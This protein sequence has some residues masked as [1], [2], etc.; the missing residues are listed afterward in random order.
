MERSKSMKAHFV[1]FY[2]PGTFFAEDTTKPIDSW[3]VEKARKM[4]R[5]I[6]E[7]Y[8]ARPFGFRFTTRERGPKALDSHVTKTS[9]MYYLGGKIESLAEVK[10]RATEADRILIANMEGNRW[11]RI[12]SGAS[13]WR[14]V[15]PL[16]DGDVVLDA[17]E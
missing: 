17:H 9:P 3:D 16:R 5:K 13:P 8:D 4:A 7:R 15:Q 10:A 6:V 12:V 1:T 11:D 2:S 14:W